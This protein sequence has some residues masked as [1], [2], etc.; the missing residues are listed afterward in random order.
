MLSL[1]SSG[2]ALVSLTQASRV[3]YH[4]QPQMP[5]TPETAGDLASRAASCWG[6]YPMGHPCPIRP[7]TFDQLI[8][9]NNPSLGT[10]KQRYWVNDEHYAG[11]GSPIVLH[12]PNESD[13]DRQVWY[14]A[15]QTADGY[16]AQ[17]IKG[18][19]I[20][21]EHR[22]YGDSSPYQELTAKTLQYLTLDQSMQDLIYFA[23]NVKL[24]F[25]EDGGTHP[26]RAPWIYSGGSYPG[27][28]ATWIQKVYPGTFWAYHATS[29]V[30]QPIAHYWQY[31]VPIER[32]MPQ[33]CSTD[34]KK[35]MTQL[36]NMIE[37]GD[38][39]RKEYIKSRFGLAGLHDDDF[40]WAIIDSLQQWQSTSFT[41][42]YEK[43]ALYNM[44]DAIEGV[45]NRNEAGAPLP[46]PGGIGAC[47]ALKNFAKWMREVHVP[48]SCTDEYWGDDKETIACWD[49][50]NSSSPYITDRSP[51]NKWNTQWQWF[52]CNEPFQ[53]WQAAAPGDNG[54]VPDFLTMESLRAQCD[55]F[56]P[57]TEGHTYG[58]NSGRTTEDIVERIGG[59]DFT[60]T[61][62]LLYV[63]GEYDP[64]IMETMSSPIRPGGPLKSTPEVPRFVVPKSAHCPDMVMSNINANEANREIH[65]QTMKIMM[66]WVSEFYSEKG[67]AQPGFD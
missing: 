36:G 5:E 15:N 57:E 31:Y 40:G 3:V 45:P 39:D 24:H 4:G 12:G 59:W 41:T 44:C 1:L 42:P 30:V 8:D 19:A 25:D 20:V 2:L 62:R 6:L 58:L 60:N 7:G 61:T 50:H 34:M 47:K 9:H 67:I 54:L 11:P 56:F 53:M 23:N 65:D 28:L 16:L 17:E 51:R 21:I 43:N 29:A 63:D 49:L 37:N 38:D 64:W 48:G 32:A 66:K 33:N 10:F 55:V 35:A 52:C 14:T 26:S 46:G 18:A 22:Y 27:A 13:A